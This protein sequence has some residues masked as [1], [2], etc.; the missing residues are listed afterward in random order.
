MI[1][2][3]LKK[4][5]GNSRGLHL[6]RFT[7]DETLKILRGHESQI[8]L[9]DISVSRFHALIEYCRG[10]V[11]LRDNHSKLGTLL[12]ILDKYEVFEDVV[13]AV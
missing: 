12:E 2:E 11:M 9:F 10:K 1:L 5:E 6:I 8:E 13:D 7:D 3:S 4:V